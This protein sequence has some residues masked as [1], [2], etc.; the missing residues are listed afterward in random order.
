[1]GGALWG[2]VLFSLCLGYFYTPFKSSEASSEDIASIYELKRLITE[3]RSTE[4]YALFL[5]S[6]QGFAFPEMAYVAGYKPSYDRGALE[7][8]SGA[9]NHLSDKLMHDINTGLFGRVY[10]RNGDDFGVT[11]YGV[12][13]KTMYNTIRVRYALCADIRAAYWQVMCR[14]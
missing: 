1:M 5:D 2:L 4:E 9:Q 10:L 7:E 12:P 6:A 3:A 14:K 11:A 8:W 13:Y